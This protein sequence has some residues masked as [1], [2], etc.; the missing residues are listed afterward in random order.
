MAPGYNIPASSPKPPLGQVVE[1][2]NSRPVTAADRVPHDSLMQ[3]QHLNTMGSRAHLLESSRLVQTENLL[4]KQAE[5][6]KKQ[7]I[8]RV[9]EQV[10]IMQ[11]MYQYDDFEEYDEEA[12]EQEIEE[13]ERLLKIKDRIKYKEMINLMYK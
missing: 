4:K 11:Q 7:N 9:T 8:P 6:L 12:L 1:T 2:S 13:E 3:S 5:I 10:S